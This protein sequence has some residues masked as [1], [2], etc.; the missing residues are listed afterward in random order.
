[1]VT[2]V[3][4][5]LHALIWSVYNTPTHACLGFSRNRSPTLRIPFFLSPSLGILSLSDCSCYCQI[6]CIFPSCTGPLFSRRSCCPHPSPPSPASHGTSDKAGRPPSCASNALNLSSSAR[7]PS[8]NP[9]KRPQHTSIR[10]PAETP[11]TSPCRQTPSI[12]PLSP[13]APV[14]RIPRTSLIIGPLVSISARAMVVIRG[15]LS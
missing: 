2:T 15:C 1:M 9:A 7:I 10:L 5:I 8:S 14:A 11:S 4:N 3:D 13:L 12:H 6:V